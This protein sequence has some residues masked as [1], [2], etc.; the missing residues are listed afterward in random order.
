MHGDRALDRTRLAEGSRWEERI[1]AC[2]TAARSLRKE[3]GLMSGPGTGSGSRPR[4]P[5]AANRTGEKPTN[6]AKC[7]CETTRLLHA[8]SHSR[9]RVR[10]LTHRVTDQATPGSVTNPS[11]TQGTPRAFGDA[12]SSPLAVAVPNRARPV[13]LTRLR[14]SIIAC[15]GVIV[16]AVEVGRPFVA[17]RRVSCQDQCRR[18]RF[19]LKNVSAMMLSVWDATVAGQERP[20]QIKRLATHC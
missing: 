7:G 13:E 6:F 15:F 3:I 2:F 14:P 12:A 1:F 17:W 18:S 5:S 9:R 19:G 20:C 4:S 16:G 11:A 8:I 10:R